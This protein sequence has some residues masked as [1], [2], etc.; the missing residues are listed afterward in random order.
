VLK[1]VERFVKDTN[2]VEATGRAR[3][4]TWPRNATETKRSRNVTGYHPRYRSVAGSEPHPGSGDEDESVGTSSTPNLL[5][6]PA[7]YFCRLLNSL[8]DFN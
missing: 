6:F 4:T 7:D 8:A 2:H 5:T 1:G 3:S